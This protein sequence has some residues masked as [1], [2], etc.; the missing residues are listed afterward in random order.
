LSAGA[1]YTGLLYKDTADILITTT[2]KAEH[3]KPYALDSSYFASRRA[4]VSFTWE[5]PGLGPRSSLALGLLGQF[6]LN[7]GEDTLNSQYLS[8]RWALRFSGGF[9]LEAAAVLG[10]AEDGDGESSVFFAGALGGS[11][12]PPGAWDDRLSLRGFYSS[13]SEGKSLS[14]F[15]PVNSLPQGQIFG[16]AP[17]GLSLVRAVYSLRPRRTLFLSVEYVYFIRT[18]T[19]S[20]QDDRE[21]QK[22]KADGY[23]LGGE[24]WGTVRWTPLPDLALSLGGGAF[25][26]GMGNVFTPDAAIRWKTALALVL[27]L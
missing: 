13:P 7:G 2:D 4:L 5:N 10:A 15:I 27:S 8:G 14:P 12:A 11:W 9:S 22:Q 6:D 3:K 18:D 20:F 17:G 1:W 25:F 19:V 23:F 26:P 21:P 24:F 16:A